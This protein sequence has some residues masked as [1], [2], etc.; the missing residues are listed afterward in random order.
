MQEIDKVINMIPFV[1]PE[2][3]SVRAL[4][5]NCR[6]DTEKILY[7][8]MFVVLQLPKMILQVSDYPRH[9]W[10]KF[11]SSLRI[12]HYNRNVSNFYK[13]CMGADF[14]VSLRTKAHVR[15]RGRELCSSA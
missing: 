13:I 9:L 1:C 14:V 8:Q 7:T 4:R 10:Y 6:K 5:E 2:G 15:G 3:G 11:Y 12:I